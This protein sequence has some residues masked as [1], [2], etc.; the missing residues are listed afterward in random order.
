[1]QGAS[2]VH[3]LRQHRPPCLLELQEEHIVRGRPL[4]QDHVGAQAHR[5]DADDLV[6]DVDERVAAD[7]PLPVR[8]QRREVVVERLGHRLELA[9]G[10]PR[11]ERR[12]GDDAASLAGLGGE[13][14]QRSVGGLLA[15]HRDRAA[16]LAAQG[17]V[18]DGPLQPRH[19]QAVEGASKQWLLGQ[20]VHFIAVGQDAR[21]DGVAAGCLL[22][23][24][25]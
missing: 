1:M 10:Q 8:L 23:T 22:Y 25:P 17:L 24:S 19:V 7:D 11:D 15:R 16:D 2:A 13:P 3:V 4:Q 5:P 12:L 21:A 9:L 18:A 14:R 20:V 6:R